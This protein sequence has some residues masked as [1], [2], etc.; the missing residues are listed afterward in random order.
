MDK[1]ILFCAVVLASGAWAEPYSETFSRITGIEPGVYHLTKPVKE[2]DEGDLEFRDKVSKRDKTQG[3]A[4]VLNGQPLASFLGGPDEGG[5]RAL[6]W[7]SDST[8]TGSRVEYHKTGTF[9]G[10]PV[11]WDLVIIPRKDG[12]TYE[13][14]VKGKTITCELTR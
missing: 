1:F 9:N 8:V 5:E 10:K 2:C 13:T 14:E 12:F 6:K 7:V 11:R 4:F 3:I